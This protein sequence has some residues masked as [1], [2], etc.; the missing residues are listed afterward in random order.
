MA[1]FLD[2]EQTLLLNVSEDV[3]ELAHWLEA[4][5]DS[6]PELPLETWAERIQQVSDRW[7]DALKRVGLLPKHPDPEREVI[8][9]TLEG[10]SSELEPTKKAEALVDR[11][12]ERVE[13]LDERV[14][15]VEKQ[16]SQEV[17]LRAVRSIR[18]ECLHMLR[19]ARSPSE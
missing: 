6:V 1:L 15:T 14:A 3:R 19:L 10:L 2:D 18:R 9:R 8:V 17:I 11:L 16:S 5:R 12:I 4:H 7:D 13:S